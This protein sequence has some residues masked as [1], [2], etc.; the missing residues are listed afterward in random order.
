MFI[1]SKTVAQLLVDA[2]RA[3][4]PPREPGEAPYRPDAHSRHAPLPDEEIR[5]EEVQQ[6]T[7]ERVERLLGMLGRSYGATNPGMM[8]GVVAGG[9]AFTPEMASQ[10]AE[11]LGLDPEDPK[12]RATLQALAAELFEW[13]KAQPQEAARFGLSENTERGAK[14]G[15]MTLTARAPRPVLQAQQRSRDTLGAA[16]IGILH[17]SDTHFHH[18]KN[19]IGCTDILSDLYE[20]KEIDKVLKILGSKADFLSGHDEA[21]AEAV[22]SFAWANRDQFHVIVVSGDLAT[23]G[24]AEDLQMARDFIYGAPAKRQAYRS[25]AG[26]HTLQ[27]AGK[28]IRVI[29]GNHDRFGRWPYAPGACHFDEVFGEVKDQGMPVW[30]RKKRVQELW[31]DGPEGASLVVLLGADLTLRP[32]DKMLADEGHFGVGYLGRGCVTKGDVDL[33]MEQTKKARRDNPGCAVFWVMHFRPGLAES[34]YLSLCGDVDYL[35]DKA[36]DAKVAGV[37]GIL[38]GHTHKE[39]AKPDNFNGL[40]VYCCGTSAECYA[41]DG[42]WLNLI[43]VKVD[44]QKRTSEV[45]GFKRFKFCD[46]ARGFLPHEECP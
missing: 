28:P 12:A 2:V 32:D 30:Q 33:L 38:C 5:L 20:A 16:E 41:P 23:K 10:V 13:A 9:N 6:A 25:A 26:S 37:K 39:E 36:A 35:R 24:D 21:V 43:T 45:V 7:G 42:N 17:I 44:R 19:T 11:R 34:K 46:N 27:A 29:P 31:K 22:A 40:S 14:T 8:L 15:E 4:P 18:R 3:S 1:P